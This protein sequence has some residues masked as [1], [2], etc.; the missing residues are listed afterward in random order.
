MTPELRT[1][2]EETILPQYAHFDS[3][4]QENHARDVIKDSLVLAAHYD[5]NIDMVYVI[6]A[7]HDLGLKYGRE[8]HHIHSG[9]ILLADQ[10]LKQWFTDEQLL[11]MRD[12][13]EDHRASKGSEPRSIYGR[14]VAEADRQ[15]DCEVTLRRTIQY[16]LANYPQLDQEGQCQR[17]VEHLQKKYADGGYLKLYI[18]QSQNAERLAQ[19]RTLITNKQLLKETLATLYTQE[20]QKS[21]K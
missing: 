18:P 11:I 5:V 2:V 15:I 13:I 19:L 4:H 6:A 1:Y 9:E 7:Y 3:A 17:A 14:I 12:A 21:T 8:F 20:I 16:G 10:S